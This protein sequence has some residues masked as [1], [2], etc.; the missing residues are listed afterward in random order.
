MILELREDDGNTFIMLACMEKAVFLKHTT[1]FIPISGYFAIDFFQLL[2]ITIPF[3]FRLKS[4]S[5]V[6]TVRSAS[7]RVLPEATQMP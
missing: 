5:M 6:K 1:S 2:A 7:S 3:Y 4:I